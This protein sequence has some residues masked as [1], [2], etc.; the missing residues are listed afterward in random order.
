[1]IVGFRCDANPKIGLGHFVRCLSIAA[2]VKKLGE[3]RLENIEIVF[4]TK[5]NTIHLEMIKQRGL[6]TI[7]RTINSEEEFLL[8][9]TPQLD[10]LL[11]DRNY[12][13]SVDIIKQIQ[14]NTPVVML[15]NI[16]E[17]S[18][19]SN[20]TI[21]PAA[22]IDDKI[23]ANDRW[24]QDFRKMLYG[25]E[26]IVL[27]QD[28]FALQRRK[29]PNKIPVIYV[30]TGGSDP[31]GITFKLM[32]WFKAYSPPLPFSVVFL[33]GSAFLLTEALD[34]EKRNIPQHIEI[35]PF[36]IKELEQAD[37]AISSF[38][39]STYELMY[40]GIP[41]LCIGHAS[42]NAA[43]SKILSTRYQSTVDLGLIDTLEKEFFFSK[44]EPFIKDVNKR[45][46]LGKKGKSLISG[47]GASK[48]SDILVEQIVK[49]DL[50]G[51]T[52]GGPPME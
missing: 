32:S 44:L 37:L 35:R 23:L 28:V 8:Q 13:Y 47:N 7:F 6:K 33:V 20:V 36:D 51:N 42:S 25:P 45:E 43:G 11:I 31:K 34:R 10:V 38:S 19:E 39:I 15:H 41:T 26:Y 46:S 1:M 21:L 17:G 2:E 52:K 48:I 4:L 16:C 40:L 27:N 9:A 22:H 24:N 3:R 5:E 29:I 50:C 30:V 12:N 18:F 14:N 49:A